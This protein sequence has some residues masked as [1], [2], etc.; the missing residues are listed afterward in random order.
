VAV[1]GQSVA[2]IV[3]QHWTKFGRNFYS[4]HDYEALDIDAANGIIKHLRTRLNKLPNK[5]FGG[6][7]IS[8]A[9]DFAYTDPVDHSVSQHQGIRIRFSDSS[10]IIFRL[11]GTG[12]EGATLRI[13]LETYESDLAKLHLDAQDALADLIAIARQLAEVKQRSGREAPAVIT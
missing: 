7:Q 11:S 10:R 13:Y 12:T 8:I 6:Q 1:R 5:S 3:H 2:E 9:D 4:R